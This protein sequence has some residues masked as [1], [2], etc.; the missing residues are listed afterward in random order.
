MLRMLLSLPMT[1]LIAI[2]F[3][4]DHR[5]NT[6]VELN[7]LVRT[8]HFVPALWRTCISGFDACLLYYDSGCA[9]FVLPRAFLE[10]GLLVSCIHLA[11]AGWAIVIFDYHCPACMSALKRT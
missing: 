11:A 1:H 4:T 2:S 10:G 9:E 7:H 6:L 8:S 3:D 5:L